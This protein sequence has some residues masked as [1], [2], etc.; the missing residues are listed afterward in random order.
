MRRVNLLHA[1][2]SP[3]NYLYMNQH[4]CRCAAC[5]GAKSAYNAAYCASH[6]EEIAAQHSVY[7]AAH[8]EKRNAFAAAYHAAHR[9]ERA[10]YNAGRREEAAAK[11]LTREYG[12]SQG[13]WDAMFAAQGNRCAIHGGELPAGRRWHTDH[14]HQT[15]T[16]RG[17]LCPDCNTALGLFR[18]DPAR[19]M[20][21]IEYLAVATP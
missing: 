10:A 8:R 4:G 1:H 9:E 11:R 20:A 13:E 15:G 3:T 14:D 7:D 5:R 12:L 18:D 19:L 6:P 21:A 16:V 17:I 2:G